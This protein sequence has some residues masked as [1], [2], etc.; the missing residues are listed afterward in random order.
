MSVLSI[1]ASGMAAAVSQLNVSAQN[2]ANS[3]SYG[4]LGDA[5][6]PSGSPSAPSGAAPK[7]YAP[8]QLVQFSLPLDE[9]G[10][11]QTT[12]TVSANPDHAVYDPSASYADSRGLVSA[13]N[14]DPVTE[15]VN[16]M[17]AL[18][19][20]KANLDLFRAGEDMMASALKLV[21]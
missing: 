12:T 13:P 17:Q 20:F 3:Q 10:G 18:T 15:A 7:A 19:Q 11:V 8:L 2:I 4:A 9:G 21:V 14:V 5:Q 6:T 1:A 16:Q